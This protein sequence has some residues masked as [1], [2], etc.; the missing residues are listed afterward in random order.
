[1]VEDEATGVIIDHPEAIPANI[2]D[3]THR[4]SFGILKNKIKKKITSVFSHV[5]FILHISKIL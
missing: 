5:G 2:E 3:G 1:L 4:L